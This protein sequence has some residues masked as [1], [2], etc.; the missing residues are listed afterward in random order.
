MITNLELDHHSRWRSLAEL[1]EAF[2]RFA[3]SG[4]GW[5]RR[6]RR[7][8]R[9]RRAPGDPLRAR[10]AS[11]A[12]A[13]P[14]RSGRERDRGRRAAGRASGPRRRRS[15]A[16]SARR[17]RPPQRR[18]R[19][20]GARRPCA[21]GGR[22]ADAGRRG[23][24]RAS[25]GV[26]RRLELKGERA[27]A[28]VYDDYAHHPTEVAAALAAARELGRARLIAVF[29]PHLYS[30]TKALA[31]EFGAALA[32]ADEIAVLEV[33]PAREE[34]VGPLEGVSGLHGRRGG[35]RARRRPPVWWLPDARARGDGRWARA[36]ERATCCVT[37]GAGDIFRLAEDAGR[38]ADGR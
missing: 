6:R 24:R 12:A 9:G 32:A 4:A 15:T 1:T 23:A 34:P 7:A 31:A 10:A 18:Q 13:G 30:R 27:G 29:Q 36:S 8:A 38:R 19:A 22:D 3:A 37:I 14:S 5:S 11:P 21:A 20:R 33:Y 35:G 25:R 17:S 28:R 2:A 16:T 26:A